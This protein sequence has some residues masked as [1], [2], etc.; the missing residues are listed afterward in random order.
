M[1]K[2]TVL[3][4]VNIFL[5][6]FF[7]ACGSNLPSLTLELPSTILQQKLEEKFPVSV[8][9]QDASV[10]LDI[11]LSNPAVIL[12][13]GR[14]KIGFRVAVDITMPDTTP[15]D[16]GNLPA[17]PAP[18]GGKAPPLPKPPNTTSEQQT[19]SLTI[20]GSVTM[21]AA[22][23]YDATQKA[24]YIMDPEVTELDFAVLPEPLV[25]PASKAME[26]VLAEKFA[27]EAI[28]L[29]QDEALVNA[30]TAVLKSVNVENGRLLL[31][32]GL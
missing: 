23:R 15:V 2:Y 10:P 32:F 22:L 16:A 20:N 18:P 19:E 7:A 12:E 25:E 1:K 3:F 28:Y 8:Q 31:E 27:T 14:D 6:T 9:E 29:P 13:E 11:M 26:Q 5:L 30:A 17:P 4:F 24:I 21:F